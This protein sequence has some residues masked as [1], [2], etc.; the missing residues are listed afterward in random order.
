[1]A[2]GG[3][4]LLTIQWKKDDKMVGLDCVWVTEGEGKWC[5]IVGIDNSLLS[6]G[7][8]TTRCVGFDCVWVT[9]GEGK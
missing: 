8:R 9:E 3:T 5:G 6:N 4:K 2:I 7:R 1:M